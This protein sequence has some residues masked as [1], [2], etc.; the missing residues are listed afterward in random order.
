MARL[1][2]KTKRKRTKELFPPK[3]KPAQ[4]FI[5][6]ILCSQWVL[7]SEQCPVLCTAQ[8][9]AS[10]HFWRILWTYPVGSC[11]TGGSCLG[12]LL[13]SVLVYRKH[14]FRAGNQATL[15]A[16]P[17]SPWLSLTKGRMQCFGWHQPL[18]LKQKPNERAGVPGALCD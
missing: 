18:I 14:V 13:Q 17:V 3:V 4:I 15:Q 16:F 1:D 2:D 12:P 8:S 7:L 6:H 11:S 9:C 10:A 5:S